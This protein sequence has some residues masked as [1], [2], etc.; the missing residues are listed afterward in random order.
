MVVLCWVGP[1]L[2]ADRRDGPTLSSLSLHLT[3]EIDAPCTQPT[4]IRQN[5][6]TLMC[7]VDIDLCVG[8]EFDLI[9]YF[10]DLLNRRLEFSDNNCAT[11]ILY[12]KFYLAEDLL[13]PR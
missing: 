8:V 3:P 5:I 4:L 2:A 9:N 1:R 13:L 7:G 6:D 11:K 10:S 12:H